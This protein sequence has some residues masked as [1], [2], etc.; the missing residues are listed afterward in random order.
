MLAQGVH[1]PDFAKNEVEHLEQFV[2]SLLKAGNT[3]S[4]GELLHTL[5]SIPLPCTSFDLDH[6]TKTPDMSSEDS[7]PCDLNL[8]DVTETD[9]DSTSVKE[10]V[11]GDSDPSSPDPDLSQTPLSPSSHSHSPPSKTGRRRRGLVITPS[12]KY[13][14][15]LRSRQIIT[16][17]MPSTKHRLDA[18]E[19]AVKDLQDNKVNTDDVYNIHE[20]L[21]SKA[22]I[23]ALHDLKV[24]LK[25]TLQREFE[26]KLNE[27]STTVEHLS[28][29]VQ[30]LETE[31]V[32]LKSKVDSLKKYSL[33]S[34]T[35]QTTPSPCSQESNS[36]PNPAPP[37]QD[38]GADANVNV[39]NSSQATDDTHNTQLNSLS[40][41]TQSSISVYNRFAILDSAD[42]PRK[43]HYKNSYCQLTNRRRKLKKKRTASSIPEK[44]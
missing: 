37:S 29:R 35:T 11:G 38:P 13:A 10:C 34:Q 26:H 33:K 42:K 31:N 28:A 41:Q 24:Q 3:N 40:H 43:T 21:N 23:E 18:L 7:V 6:F 39:L 8:Q 16:S 22:N 14:R 9:Q 5:L 25:N 20:I 19:T 27:Y 2:L 4:E 12:A 30:H 17:I 44:N 36:N 32:K 1:C 15:N